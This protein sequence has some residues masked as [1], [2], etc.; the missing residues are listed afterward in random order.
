VSPTPT[1][2]HVPLL[3]LIPPLVLRTQL[4]PWTVW[5]CLYASA[6]PVLMGFSSETPRLLSHYPLS[7]SS[8][9]VPCVLC[10]KPAQAVMTRSLFLVRK[11]RPHNDLLLMLRP[12]NV[13]IAMMTFP[14]CVLDRFLL[15]FRV[16]VMLIFLTPGPLLPCLSS[17]SRPFVRSCPAPQACGPG[18][19]PLGYG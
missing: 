3:T 5:I 4:L 17:T 19:C 14:F 11:S 12:P 9:Q 18:R 2:R 15:W 8:P 6:S 16:I 10:F 13:Q 7:Y 1:P